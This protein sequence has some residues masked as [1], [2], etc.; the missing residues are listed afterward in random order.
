VSPTTE[1][2]GSDTTEPPPEGGVSAGGGIIGLSA[3]G[4][5]AAVVWLTAGALV[6]LVGATLFAL[7]RASGGE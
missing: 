7:R 3:L 2:P 1:P 5:E 6:L 4:G